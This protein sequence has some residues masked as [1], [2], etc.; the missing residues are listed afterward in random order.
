M[1]ITITGKKSPFNYNTDSHY[2]L[3]TGAFLATDGTR[4]VVVNDSFD[5]NYDE[6]NEYNDPNT[7]VMTFD[8][9]YSVKKDG[10]YVICVTQ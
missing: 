7:Y 9:L 1:S 8:T 4:M 3:I 10:G 5:D 6:E 2:I